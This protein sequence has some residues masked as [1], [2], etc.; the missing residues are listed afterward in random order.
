MSDERFLLRRELVLTRTAVKEDL[1]DGR[2][3][4]GMCRWVPVRAQAREK[5][6][7]LGRR[8]RQI[9]YLKSVKVHLRSSRS[10]RLQIQPASARVIPCLSEEGRSDFGW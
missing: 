1:V 7:I 2:C 8:R 9:H 5:N 10:V 4:D 3:L 6:V